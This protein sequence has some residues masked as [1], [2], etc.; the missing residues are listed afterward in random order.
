MKGPSSMIPLT[1]VARLAVRATV[2]IILLTAAYLVVSYPSLPWLLPVHFKRGG[3]ANG[4]QYKTLSRVLLPAFVQLSLALTFGAIAALLLSR[5]STSTAA[6]GE[7]TEAGD[8]ATQ[9]ASGG[10]VAPDVQ[11]AMAAAETVLLMAFIWVAFQAYAAYALV[12]MWTSEIGHL[13]GLYTTLEWLGLVLTGVVAVRGHARVGRP[14]PRPY[15]PE[16]WR[17]G[18]LYKNPNDPALFVPTRDGAKWTLNFGRPGAAALL[19]VVLTIGVIGPT[20]ILILVLRYN[21]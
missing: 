15:V 18:H 12:H 17:L 2:L 1:P 20:A 7:S 21:F 9:P 14:S 3:I 8:V 19:G 6:K 4:W 5:S 11:A 10:R 13:G 16:H